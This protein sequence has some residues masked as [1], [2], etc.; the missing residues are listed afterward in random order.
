ML[1]RLLNKKEYVPKFK[2][3]T[4]GQ[5]LVNGVKVLMKD[6]NGHL[7]GNYVNHTNPILTFQLARV[8]G[9]WM[10]I[11]EFLKRYSSMTHT[12]TPILANQAGKTTWLP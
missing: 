8:G 6:V 1:A 3:I 2:R 5:Y 10:P 4:Q 9:G 12:P 7:V 11:E